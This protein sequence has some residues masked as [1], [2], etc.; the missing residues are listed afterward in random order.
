MKKILIVAIFGLLISASTLKAQDTTRI[1]QNETL[2]GWT[3]VKS[4]EVPAALRQE[5]SK[6]VYSGWENSTLY[7]NASSDKYFVKIKNEN[8]QTSTYYFDASGKPTKP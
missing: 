5:L 4:S 7:R 6:A 2:A 3:K 1:K 8:G